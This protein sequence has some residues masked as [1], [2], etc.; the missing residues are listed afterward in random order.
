MKNNRRLKVR[1]NV[2]VNFFLFY[3]ELTPNDGGCNMLHISLWRKKH[4]DEMSDKQ[5]FQKISLMKVYARKYFKSK[6][7]LIILHGR[8]T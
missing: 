6:A 1:V 3:S 2:V 7:T 8:K 4:E 5:Y